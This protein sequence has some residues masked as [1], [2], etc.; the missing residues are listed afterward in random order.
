MGDNTPDGNEDLLL[1]HF[2]AV[3]IEDTVPPAPQIFK[4]WQVFLERVN[5]LTK[6]VHVPTLQPLILEAATNHESIPDNQQ[7]LLFAIYCSATVALSRDESLSILGMSKDAAVDRFTEGVKSALVKADFMK[8]YDMVTIQALM[9]YLVCLPMLPHISQVPDLTMIQLALYSRGR[10]DVVW[11]LSGVLMRMARKL[12]IHRDGET[13]QLPPFETEM[14]RR[15]WWQLVVLDFKSATESGIRETLLPSD[16]DTKMPSNV[17]DADMSPQSPAIHS[18]DGPTEMVWCL[19]ICTLAQFLNDNHLP[20]FDDDII[21]GQDTE[22]GSPEYESYL[23]SVERYSGI[24]DAL[25]ARL[26]AAE[27]QYCNPAAGLIHAYAASVR[28]RFVDKM[29][30]QLTP[31]REC[32]EWGTE[33]NSTRDN[34]FRI[35][36]CHHE[37]DVE[38]CRRFKP[39]FQWNFRADGLLYVVGEMYMR[40]QTGTFAERFWRLAEGVYEHHEDLWDMRRRDNV[41]LSGFVVQAW[42]VREQT[43]LEMGVPCET[44]AFVQKLLAS[45][46]QQNADALGQHQTAGEQADLSLLDPSAA[47]QL[48]NPSSGGFMNPTLAADADES[49][50]E[51]KWEGHAPTFP[52]HT[53]GNFG[54]PHDSWG[55]W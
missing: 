14:R 10:R 53:F 16:W 2:S 4:L 18:R 15:L 19:I 23:K 52:F 38:S 11:F 24:L 33:V 37:A 29:R 3:N 1:S 54:G 40:P 12:G 22:A 32:A 30:V 48:V 26:L 35:S 34:L 55:G 49:I 13:L 27:R 9:L 17:N 5:P 8:N 44:P 46:P 50:D 31:M 25:D 47:G 36:L 42:R 7:A 21:R 39:F 41:R 45:L 51:L 20:N 28:Q 43:L 6:A